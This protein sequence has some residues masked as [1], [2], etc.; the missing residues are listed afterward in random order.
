M[1]SSIFQWLEASC[2][3]IISL[4][5]QE[6]LYSTLLFV[7]IWGL[8][9][10]LRGKT[11]HWQLGLWALIILRLLLPPDISSPLSARKLLDY[12]P[13]IQKIETATQE[14]GLGLQDSWSP[15]SK[16]TSPPGVEIDSYEQKRAEITGVGSDTD[17]DQYISWPVILVLVWFVGFMLSLFAF[18]RKLVA[19]HRL[20]QLAAP[21]QDDKIFQLVER[22]RR[23]FEI[24][25]PVRIVSS[26][27][28][29]SPFTLGILRPKIF[30]PSILLQSKEMITIGSIIAHEMVHIKS[31]DD[32][33][34]K[35]QNLVQIVYFF[36]P[37]V[38]YANRQIN[39]ARERICDA[40]ALSRQNISP[41]TYGQGILNVLRLNVVSFGLTD[42]FPGFGNH[43]KTIECTIRYVM[44]GKIMKARNSLFVLSTIALIGMFLLP[45]APDKTDAAEQYKT[46]RGNTGGPPQMEGWFALEF[47]P[48]VHTKA[49]LPRELQS[50]KINPY[51]RSPRHQLQSFQSS[52]DNHFRPGI[53]YYTG[54]KPVRAVAGGI[55]HFVGELPAWA[56]KANGFY[57]RVA[58]D[59]YDGL[60]KDYY[61]RATLYRN[62]AYRS[63]YYYL[64]KVVVEHWQTVKR[65]QVI[66]YGSSYGTNH[67]E[68]A[69]IVLEERGNW[70]N[71][72]DYGPKHSFMTYWDGETNLE[73]DLEEMNDRLD[74][75]K[76]IVRKLS[77]YYIKRDEDNLHNKVHSVIDTEKFRNYPVKWSTIDRFRYLSH[78]YSKDPGLFPGLSTAEFG[79]MTKAFY[80]NQ[81]IILTLPFK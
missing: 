25:R 38:W 12:L 37:V 77:D 32:L 72:D 22:W 29:L 50:N 47:D 43:R 49:K 78:L 74:K 81:P 3:A 57:V 80:R 34:I 9:Y 68:K 53:E 8:A 1:G 16:S 19:F 27:E 76:E 67:K 30:V 69:K 24:R 2:E 42:P 73:I 15:Y 45:M 33:W 13:V 6:V 79:N 64:S 52:I 28:Y 62:Q 23:E 39:F 66:G 5:Y 56:G 60:K 36:H 40:N 61:P 63:S 17:L 70:V 58:H 44:E 18:L 48:R 26:D 55:V 65:G 4:L 21:V 51:V 54:G 10:C 41:R 59:F 75:Q 7:V 20:I 14:T 71:P 46:V 35:A 31:F 11:P